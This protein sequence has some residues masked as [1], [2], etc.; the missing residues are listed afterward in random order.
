MN[1]SGKTALITGT[2]SGIGR[3]LTMALIKK[4]C[5]VAGFSRREADINNDNYFHI[6]TDIT[7]PEE[8]AASFKTALDKLG[9]KIHILINNAGFGSFKRLEDFPIEEWE[10]MYAVN[11]HGLFYITKYVVPVMRQQKEG[12]IINISSIAGLTAMEMGTAYNSTKW[13]VRA[14]SQALYK[15]VK[16]DN[17]KVTCLFPGSVNTAFFDEVEATTANDTML[18]A[19]DVAQTIIN[20]LET[21]DNFNPSELEI[22]P[23]NVKYR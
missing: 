6:K 15:E 20:L 18:H 7:K 12:H 1:L 17:V 10:Q 21:P 23:M 22:R 16:S 19:D 11:V 4:G 13:A 2:S 14:I 3:E 9:G 5:K 8:V